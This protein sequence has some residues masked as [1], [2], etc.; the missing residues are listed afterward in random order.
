MI[1]DTDP[2]VL[3][4]LYGRKRGRKRLP[5]SERKWN[6]CISLS[7]RLGEYALVQAAKA[8]Y[9]DN[10]SAGISACIE[11]C[12]L[13]EQSALEAI[14]AAAERRDQDAVRSQGSAFDD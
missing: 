7:P 2:A 13:Q 8:K 10:L 9:P 5:L 6:V 3:R 14:Q 1:E 12:L 11:R 4:A